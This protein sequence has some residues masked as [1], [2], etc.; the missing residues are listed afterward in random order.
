MNPS[1]HEQRLWSL[2]LVLFAFG[3]FDVCLEYPVH[4]RKLVPLYIDVVQTLRRASQSETAL[5][6]LL[7]VA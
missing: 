4:S 3:Q 1:E 6:I 7:S 2:T 5:P